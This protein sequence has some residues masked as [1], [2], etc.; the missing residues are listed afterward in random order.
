MGLRTTGLLADELFLLAHD[1]VTGRPRVGPRVLGLGLAGALLGELVLCGR[2]TLR[3]GV[4]VVVDARPPSDA[5][6][7]MVLDQLLRE[8]LP[9]GVR[10]WLVFLAVSAPQRVAERLASAGLIT[11]SR[12]RR[13]WVHGRW[14]PADMNIAFAPLAR[15]RMLVE[16]GRA[17]S[18]PEV[19]LAG[20]VVATGLAPI[21]LWSTSP[22]AAGYLDHAVSTLA[23]PL[24]VLVAQTQA[25]VGN[26]VLSHRT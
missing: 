26:A 24:G 8:P 1:D 22:H 4:L 19:S 9:H 7:H 21:V 11:R 25:A 14:V 10:D 17:M 6:A 15:L 12:S 20:L 3:R 18:A 13:P 23:E 2:V 16:E 5:V